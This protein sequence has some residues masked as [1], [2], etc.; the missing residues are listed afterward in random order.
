M[1]R[2]QIAV[3]G[4]DQDFCTKK[5][6]DIAYNVGYEIGKR[7]AVLITG[8]GKGVMEAAAKGAKAAGGLTVGI[9]FGGTKKEANQYSDIIIPTGFG[10]ARDE[11][12]ANASDAVI[13]VGGG[14][15]TLSEATY[16]YFDKIPIYSMKN[17]GGTA[18]KYSNQ[19]LD[20]RR[21]VKIVGMTNPIE[22][23]DTIFDKFKVKTIKGLAYLQRK[24]K[25]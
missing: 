7:G 25:K 22:V 23:L 17:S 16:A 8:G 14:V 24:K 12:N 11:I 2:L 13:L 20:Q 9:L 18:T 21:Y 6:Y 5:A 3:L 4:S 10:F 19:Y 15:G 1:R